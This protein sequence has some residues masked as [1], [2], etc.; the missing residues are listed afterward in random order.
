MILQETLIKILI[1]VHEFCKGY[2]CFHPILSKMYAEV[3]TLWKVAVFVLHISHLGR[4]REERE[5][6]KQQE[7]YTKRINKEKVIANLVRTHKRINKAKA[8]K[9]NELNRLKEVQTL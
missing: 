8:K 1:N 3:N 7:F 4:N 2:T 5:I 9:D 6:R